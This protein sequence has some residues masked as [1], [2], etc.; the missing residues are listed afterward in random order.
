MRISASKKLVVC[1]SLEVSLRHLRTALVAPSQPMSQDALTVT[2]APVGFRKR[3]S[4]FVF[5]LRQRN[6]RVLPKHLAA[7]FF[8]LFDEYFFRCVL[9]NSKDKTGRVMAS[10]PWK[11]P[12]HGALQSR[13]MRRAI[14]FQWP[15]E[16]RSRQASH[17]VPKCARS[18]SVARDSCTGPFVLSTTT[19]ETP[20]A[21]S[22]HASASPTGP[23][24]MMSTSGRRAKAIASAS[25]RGARQYPRVV[26]SHRMQ[27]SSIV[28]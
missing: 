10:R 4:Y 12:R 5:R 8:E 1:V 2:S 27:L 28:S 26:L 11:N 25:C 13:T 9:W 3:R 18:I 16:H 17:K 23:A 22:E 14:V 6:K 15:A 24:P 21:R 20:C 7:Q 19:H